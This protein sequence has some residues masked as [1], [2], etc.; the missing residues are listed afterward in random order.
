LVQGWGCQH[1]LSEQVQQRHQ[2]GVDDPGERVGDGLGDAT[3]DRG[4]P[5]VLAVIAATAVVEAAAVRCG[6]LSTLDNGSVN[7]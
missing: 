2:R 7:A 5:A 1:G 4:D 6:R 3:D